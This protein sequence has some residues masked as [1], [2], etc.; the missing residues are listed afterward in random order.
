MEYRAH[1]TIPGFPID[2]EG[3]RALDLTR[4][5]DEQT[6]M[7]PA[8]AVP[9]AEGQDATLTLATNAPDEAFA[10][11]RM[12]A[13]AT[14]GLEALNLGHLYPTRIELEPVE[15]TALATA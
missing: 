11:R 3:D 12:V 1:I 4:W 15:Q 8:M 7:R 5:I 13:A 6:D 14:R 9:V 2:P 10:T